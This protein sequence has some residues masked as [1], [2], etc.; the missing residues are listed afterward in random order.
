MKHQQGFTLIELLVALVVFSSIVS[1]TMLSFDQG[2]RNWQRS[3]NRVSTQGDL[4]K[5]E[6]WLYP[7]FEQ[8]IAAEYIYPT[9]QSGTYFE[10]TSDSMQFVS[11][12]PIL[13]GPGRNAAVN[14]KVERQNGKAKLM[15]RQRFNADIQRGIRWGDEEWFVLVEGMKTIQLRFLAGEHMPIVGGL[16]SIHPDLRRHYRTSPAWLDDFSGFYEESLPQRIAI[17]MQT[18]NDEKVEWEFPVTYLSGAFS[19]MFG[20]Q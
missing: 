18:V 20:R 7:V 3:I 9:G 10:A 19:P 5:R 1:L 2:V 8:A 11:S 12:A 13:T 15:Y 4:F 6:A 16:D 14:F 17:S